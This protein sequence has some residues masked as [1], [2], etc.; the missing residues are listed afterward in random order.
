MAENKVTDT[1]S[2]KP[3]LVK[4]GNRTYKVKPLTL[5]QVYEI[6]ELM[7]DVK[8]VDN[9]DN[10][11]LISHTLNNP[12]D[13][14]AY[15][16]IAVKVLLRGRWKRALFGGYI[17]K[18]LNSESFRDVMNVIKDAFDYSFFLQ[19]TIFLKGTFMTKKMEKEETRHGGSWEEL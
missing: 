5:M 18:H 1:L 9:S 2:Q 11:T 6:G 7:K 10:E 14:R 15:V 16:E 12:N 17:R 4:V 13:A 19:S 8:S 3:V